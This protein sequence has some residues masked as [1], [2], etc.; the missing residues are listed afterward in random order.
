MGT[1][2]RVPRFSRNV[3]SA[4]VI[5]AYAYRGSVS[6]NNSCAPPPSSDWTEDV[7]AFNFWC[8]YLIVSYVGIPVCLGMV[9]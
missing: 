9:V 4:P 2:T 1:I 3:K 8:T 7:F 6:P 5:V